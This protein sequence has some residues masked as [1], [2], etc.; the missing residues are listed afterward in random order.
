MFIN[1]SW[2]GSG[3][4]EVGYDASNGKVLIRIDP[5]YYRPTEVDLL[6]GDASKAKS[7]LGWKNNISFK[8]LVKEMVLSD[9]KTT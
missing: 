5:E 4:D 6:L 1:F 9:S 3:L 8:D 7:E 2:K